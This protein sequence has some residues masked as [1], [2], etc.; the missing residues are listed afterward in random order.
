VCRVKRFRSGPFK[1]SDHGEDE[2][3]TE[4]EGQARTEDEAEGDQGQGLLRA[5]RGAAVRSFPEAR[6]RPGLPTLERDMHPML[7]DPWLAIFYLVIDVEPCP[8]IVSVFHAG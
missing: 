8:L 3:G 7:T 4:D 2:G 5:P 1:D 6:G